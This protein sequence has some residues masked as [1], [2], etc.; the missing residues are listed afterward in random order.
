VRRA[1]RALGRVY[2]PQLAKPPRRAA[3]RLISCG[4]RRLGVWMISRSTGVIPLHEVGLGDADPDGD[5]PRGV[6]RLDPYSPSSA[7][8]FAIFQPPDGG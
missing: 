6:A 2:G 4:L 5:L 1:V 8:R 3:A 7:T